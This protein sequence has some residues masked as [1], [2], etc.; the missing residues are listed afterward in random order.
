[1]RVL[2]ARGSE[3]ERAFP[4]GVVRQLYEPAVAP[5]APPSAARRSPARPGSS[6]GSSPPRASSQHRERRFPS[7]RPL[8]AHGEPLGRGA[9]RA[10]SRR[11]A[12]GRPALDRGARVP[13][14]PA[15]G[16]SGA[17]RDRLAGPR[18]RDSTARC[19][20]SLGREPAA[21]LL[22][23]GALSTQAT[24]ALSAS[25]SPPYGDRCVLRRLPRGDRRQPAAR[26]RAR[27]RARRRRRRG[28]Q[29]RGG[30]RLRDRARGGRP[31]RAASAG[32]PSGRRPGARPLG[33]R[34]RRRRPAR[35]RGRRSRARPVGGRRGRGR[36]RGG[37][38][39]PRARHARFV[40]PLVRAAVYASIGPFEQR[41]AHAEAARLLAAAGRPPEQIAAHVLQLAPEGSAERGRDPADGRAA[42]GRRRR[43]RARGRLSRAGS[44]GAAGARSNGR[45][46]SSSWAPPSSS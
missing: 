11:P 15:R 41:E 40:H 3:M 31:C 28:P 33:G 6:S 12:L 25:G 29:R 46:S 43:R 13:R 16:A 23:P 2:A 24:A 42:L 44:R 32:G 37:A 19:S 39:A 1:M 20:T 10:P 45:R 17:A 18:A 21:H 34:A 8:L 5:P 30:T 26:C 36:A 14:P 4:F 9:A 35:R 7:T 22:A 27:E 38:G